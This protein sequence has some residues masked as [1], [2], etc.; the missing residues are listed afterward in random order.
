MARQ[1][2]DPRLAQRAM[3]I[4]ITNGS[5]SL[6]LQA[7]QSWD[8]LTPASDT[9]PKEVLVTLLILSDRWS[10]AIQPAINLLKQQTPAQQ[11]NTLKQLQ[12]LLAKA[13][14]ESEALN[15]FYQI[16]STIKLPPNDATLMYTYAMAAEKVGR[17]DVMEKILREILS[18]NPNDVN[19]L[20]AL[21]YSLADRNLKL[22]EAF[23]LINKAHQLSPKDGFI[24]DSLGW[25]NFRLGKNA[26]ALEQLQQAFNIKPEADI[27]AHAGEVLWVMNQPEQAEEMWRQGQKLDANNSTLKETLKRLKP[28]WSVA[29]RV[30]K[31]SWDGR[32]AVKVTGLT[33]AQNQGGSG[34]FTLMQE[35]LNYSAKGLRGT[36][37]KYFPNDDIAKQYERK[38][39]MIANRV[40]GNRMGNGDEASGDGWYFRGRGIVQ[41][42]G[43]NNYTK[44]SQSLFESNVLVE[45]PDLLLEAEYAIHSACWFW[46]AA[47]LNELSDSGDMKTMTKRINGGFIGL[48]DRINHYN[49]AIEILT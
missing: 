47:R 26:I 27:A 3:E 11:E 19:A 14:D 38:P 20:N 45:N 23:I 43:K 7:A 4:A 13:K 37:G 9:K 44:C 49:H 31:G 22:P 48:E 24:L 12:S 1:Y 15:A 2:N 6:A 17:L 36:F 41:I 25:I 28:A 33:N 8:S 39:Q 34:G 42:T 10:D 40:Y 21:G 5:P 30:S 32:F 18:K 46:S 16:A 35:N 29:E